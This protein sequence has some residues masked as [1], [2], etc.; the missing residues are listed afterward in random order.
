LAAWTAFPGVKTPKNRSCATRYLRLRDCFRF[1]GDTTGTIS[2]VSALE[3]SRCRTALAAPGIR[4]PHRRCANDSPAHLKDREHPDREVMIIDPLQRFR[5]D[6]VFSVA[7]IAVCDVSGATTIAFHGDFSGRTAA[8][9]AV[10]QQ[11]D[12]GS[13]RG[14]EYE[15]LP[16]RI[17]ADKYTH[18]PKSAKPPQIRTTP[19]TRTALRFQL[20]DIRGAQISITAM[21]RRNASAAQMAF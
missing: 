5:P 7:K 17:R 21:Q 9:L 4:L 8:K 19:R 14:R 18:K 16:G 3:V 12:S 15:V 11:R 13:I 6:I 1:G 20:F 2:L 10:T